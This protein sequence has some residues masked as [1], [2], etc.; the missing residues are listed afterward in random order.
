MFE[1]AFRWK[2]S[3]RAS[4]KGD[5]VRLSGKNPWGHLKRKFPVGGGGGGIMREE[6]PV[7]HF[8]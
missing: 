5:R 1:E 7:Y 3:A 2:V 8:H 4:L 6:N